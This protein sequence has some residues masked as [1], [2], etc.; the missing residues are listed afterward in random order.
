MNE[1]KNPDWVSPIFGTPPTGPEAIERDG[2]RYVREWP[3]SKGEP[4][5]PY[6]ERDGLRYVLDESDL[7]T[8]L[9]PLR[10]INLDTPEKAPG[11]KITK[12][13]PP[14]KKVVKKPKVEE[15]PEPEEDEASLPPSFLKLK[16]MT[17]SGQRRDA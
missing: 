3:A 7:N 4:K 12:K 2:R 6:I 5:V 16:K 13:K 10:F 1:L 14:S 9:N 8:E 11:Y 15:P 17:E